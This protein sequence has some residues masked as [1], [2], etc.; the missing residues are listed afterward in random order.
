MHMANRRLGKT[1]SA[2]VAGLLAIFAALPGASFQKQDFSAERGPRPQITL[3]ISL[4]SLLTFLGS[5]KGDRSSEAMAIKLI[6]MHGLSFR[7]TAEDIEKLRKA[8]ASEDLLKAIETAE[9][10]IPVVKQGRLAVGCEPVDCEVRVSGN[11]IGTTTRGE[12]PWITLPEGKV[13]V[14]AAK[15]N[16][17]PIQGEQEVPIRQ[18]ELTRIRFQFKISRAGLM[19]TGANLFQ[20][21]RRSIH[22]GEN[23]PA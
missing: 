14:S 8:S 10:P 19:A 1:R 15:T 6:E 4:Q 17:D 13:I 3:I 20:Q 12:I 23:E 18:N 11:L 9:K 5:S 7:P 21:M 2:A 16:Y 22:T